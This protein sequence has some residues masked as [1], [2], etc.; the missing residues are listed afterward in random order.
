MAS[1]EALKREMEMMHDLENLTS[2]LEQTAARTI[3][4]MRTNILSSRAY[5]K[6]VWR[7]YGVLKQLT[8]PSPEVVHKHLVVGIGIDWG[9]PGALLNRVM[10]RVLDEQKLHEADLLIAGKMSHSRFKGKGDH[11]IHFFSSPKNATLAN[12]QPI[13]KVIAGY[14]K[15]TMVYPSFESLSKQNILTASFSI[16]DADKTDPEAEKNRNNTVQVIDPERFITDP[17][18][19]ELANYLSEAIVGLT[20]HHYFSESILAYS[21]AQMVA[22]RNSHD[23]AKQEG[24]HLFIRYN[25]ARREEID[26]KLRELYGSRSGHAANTKNEEES[27]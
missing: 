25:K 13:Y 27:V 2:M 6:E 9:M 24:K 17:N 16:A 21:A 4:Q 12:I 23:N 11:T 26:S 19:Q 22:M 8:P 18:P 3:A 10:D 7:I 14:A 20:V 1:K 15:V 5:F